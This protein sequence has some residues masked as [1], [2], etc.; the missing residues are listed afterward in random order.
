VVGVAFV[1]LG[2]SFIILSVLIGT[3]ALMPFRYDFGIPENNTD[4]QD[5]LYNKTNLS[6]NERIQKLK[7][8]II[9][10]LEINTAAH[11]KKVNVFDWMHNFHY[12]GIALLFVG[13]GIIFLPRL[14]G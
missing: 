4:L 10:S 9:K 13:C 3:L 6:P 2:I 12:I 8:V 14:F 1:V 7:N 11:D 5:L